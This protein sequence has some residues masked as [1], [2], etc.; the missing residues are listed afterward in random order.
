M[1]KLRR[2]DTILT[3]TVSFPYSS[4][5]FTLFT[6]SCPTSFYSRYS[7]FYIFSCTAALRVS[8]FFW[9]WKRFS[10]TSM[11]TV[12]KKLD[13]LVC[14]EGSWNI[15]LGWSFCIV[16]FLI[17]LLY[18]WEKNIIFLLH[19]WQFFNFHLNLFTQQQDDLLQDFIKIIIHLIFINK[20]L[21]WMVQ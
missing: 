18:C 16:L 17:P 6:N 1:R 12:K 3:P 15:F 14:L 13:I 5:L 20:F 19:S 8:R 2:Y 10:G 4:I 7:F 11:P 21:D 9:G